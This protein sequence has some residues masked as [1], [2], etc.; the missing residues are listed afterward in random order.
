[1]QTQ[2]KKKEEKKWTL[3]EYKFDVHNVEVKIILNS[4]NYNSVSRAKC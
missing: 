3:M 4:R 2:H 1:M